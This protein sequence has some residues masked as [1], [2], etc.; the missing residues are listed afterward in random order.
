MT[1]PPP[2]RTRPM[3]VDPREEPTL[4]KTARVSITAGEVPLPPPLLDTSGGTPSGPRYVLGDEIARGGMGAVLHAHDERLNRDL[5]V[6]VLHADLRDSPGLR[7]RFA[8]EA[9]IAGQL[10]HPGVVPVYDLGV[11][12]DGRPF[13]AMK[14]VKGR[15]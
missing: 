5:A 3:P 8:E 4:E 14:L 9:Q 10:Q 7:Q 6:K 11:L 2:R 12:A 1:S 13:F 15:T